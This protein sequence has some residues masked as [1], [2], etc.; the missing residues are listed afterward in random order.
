MR[1]WENRGNTQKFTISKSFYAI[2][3]IR[4]SR[5]GQNQFICISHHVT[6]SF[7]YTVVYFTFLGFNSM[8]IHKDSTEAH[9]SSLNWCLVKWNVCKKHENSDFLYCE[10]KFIANCHIDQCFVN[11]ILGRKKEA[12]SIMVVSYLKRFDLL[13]RVWHHKGST[14]SL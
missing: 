7:G 5:Y 11:F 1:N 10:K 6:H 8:I 9:L 14:A 3:L 2:V 4:W 12:S 13:N